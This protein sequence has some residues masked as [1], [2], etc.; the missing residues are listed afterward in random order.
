MKSLCMVDDNEVD[1]YQVRRVVEKSQKVG[2]FY[3]FQD[4][5]E[6]IEHFID[7]E[8]SKKKFDG[9]FPPTAIL[10]DINMPRMNGFEFLA[11]YSKLPEEARESYI[12]AMLTSSDQQKDKEKMLDFNLVHEYFIKPFTKEHLNKVVEI[13]CK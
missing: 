12:I 2:V 7:F 13:V 3:S 8:E 9:S 1:I 6:A 11:E 10:L 5:K 4:G